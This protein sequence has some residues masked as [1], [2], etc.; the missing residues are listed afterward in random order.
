M[1]HKF[2][3]LFDANGKWTLPERVITVGGVQHDLD[4]YAEQH[5]IEL[6]DAKKI[7]PSKK[8]DL[9]VNIDGDMGQTQDESDTAES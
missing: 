9:E 6:P 5:G 7:K 2:L 1:K 8:A 3:R 4:D